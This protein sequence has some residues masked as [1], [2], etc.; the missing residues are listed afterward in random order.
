MLRAWH[1]ESFRALDLFVKANHAR[2]GVVWKNFAP[3]FG[4][5]ADD[6]VHSSR[7][8]PWFTD[9]GDCRDKLR[10]FVRVQNVK[11]Q[12]RMRGGSKSEDSGLRRVHGGIISGDI[13]APRPF[14]E[15]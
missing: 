7:G 6:E 5:K 4:P 1:N 2:R 11:F 10:A 3:E 8:G 12:V 13:L 9:S 15:L 14:A